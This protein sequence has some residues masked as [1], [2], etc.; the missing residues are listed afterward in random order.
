MLVT[1]WL[2][3]IGSNLSALWILIAN[4]FM[5]HPVGYEIQ[6][7]RAVMTDFGALVFNPYVWHQFPHTVLGG[8]TTGAFFVLGISAYHLIRNNMKYF[9]KSHSKLQPYL[10]LLQYC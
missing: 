8:F 4:S 5:Q 7:T 10:G 2:V 1:I 6:G 9:S 3:A